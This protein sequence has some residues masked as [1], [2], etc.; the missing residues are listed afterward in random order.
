[1]NIQQHEVSYI[2]WKDV[3]EGIK[4]SVRPEHADFIKQVF[5]D[6][7]EY[8]ME[9]DDYDWC[10]GTNKMSLVQFKHIVE[11]MND[12]VDD[13]LKEHESIEYIEVRDQN[14]IKGIVSTLMDEYYKNDTLLIDLES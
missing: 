8:I 2:T 9:T 7:I 5:A 6:L 3:V 10:F 13:F 14:M 11:M 4:D 12:Y 1:M